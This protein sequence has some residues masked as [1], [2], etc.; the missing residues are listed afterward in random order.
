M[1]VNPDIL[2]GQPPPPRKAKPTTKKAIM[3]EFFKSVGIVQNN[4]SIIKRNI[5]KL[6]SMRGSVLQA[7]TPQQEAGMYFLSN[8]L[9][10]PQMSVE[11]LT[12][13]C[14]KQTKL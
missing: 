7:T 12:I 14:L 2:S 11:K 9:Q 3:A 10:F 1:V 5:D 6:D 13:L 8:F 4:L